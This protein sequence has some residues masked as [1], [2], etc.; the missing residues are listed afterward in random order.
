MVSSFIHTL[1]SLPLPYDDEPTRV[2]ALRALDFDT[3]EDD[4]AMLVACRLPATLRAVLAR[5]A[6]DAAGA[7]AVAVAPALQAAA[8]ALVG[9]LLARRSKPSAR[10]SPLVREAAALVAIYFRED[11]L[12]TSRCTKWRPPCH[13]TAVRSWV[14]QA[15]LEAHEKLHGSCLGPHC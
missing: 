11:T 10:A 2:A 7:P 15:C 6:D 14:H 1:A 4:D 8:R 12:H 13:R 9:R 3:R 5:D